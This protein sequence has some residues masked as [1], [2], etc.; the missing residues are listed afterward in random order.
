MTQLALA[1]ARAAPFVDQLDEPY[2][3]HDIERPGFTAFVTPGGDQ[4]QISLPLN[5]LPVY[6]RKLQVG[7]VDAYIAQNEFFRRNRRAV[8]CWRLTSC[9]VDLDTYKLDSLYG[10][11]AEALTDKLLRVCDDTQIPPPSIVIYSGRGLQ[12]KWLLETPVPRSAM[13]RWN[14][15]QRLLGACLAGMGADL[16]ALDASRVLRLVGS[17]NS[18]SGETVRIVHKT[19][20]P[21][22]GG[23]LGPAGVV[24]YDFDTLA[25]E[26]MPLSREQLALRRA[27][28][29][30]HCGH[31]IA[32]QNELR[33]R[34]QS[35]RDSL[36]VVSGESPSSVTAQ[37]LVPSKL[38]W[39]RLG[40]LRK[41]AELRNGQL[42]MPSKQRNTFVFLGA[43]FL[44]SALVAPAFRAEVRELAREFAPT[45]TPAQVQHCISP[46]LSRLEAATRGEKVEFQGRQVDPRYRFSNKTL[47]DWLGI[48][49][50]EMPQMTT[51]LSDVEARRRD[52]ARHELAR[53]KKGI[54][55]R[56]VYCGQ[57]DEK[58]EMARVLR[59]AGKS[60]REIA[61]EMGIGH[62]SV[63]RYCADDKVA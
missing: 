11:P 37:R 39:D 14:L 1:L 58:A 36:V 13:P 57:K 45:W 18:K 55:P 31:D 29:A 21:T 15:V 43:C 33:R 4:R 49:D 27:E 46:T 3:Y 12:A 56:A 6:L 30:A 24:V 51:I 52:A 9:Y 8:N 42:G 34:R 54:R 5:Q 7:R 22:L 63:S 38:A 59:Q 26:M 62:A 19:C 61:R 25:N 32:R 2:L 10:R 28:V 60:L 17:V 16:K 48:T 35:V 41:L 50:E 20:T 47:V 40:D 53:R 44:A 23:I